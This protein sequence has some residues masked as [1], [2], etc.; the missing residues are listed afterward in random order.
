[1]SLIFDHKY[2]LF[3]ICFLVNL[4]VVFAQ[5]VQDDFE[6]NGTITTWFGD[7]CDIN[8]SFTNPFQINGNQSTTVLRYNDTGGQFANVRFDISSNFDLTQ[9]NSFSIKILCPFKWF[10]RGTA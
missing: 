8:T 2:F 6:G 4:S 10:N 9:N 5:N 1:M 3:I 7:N